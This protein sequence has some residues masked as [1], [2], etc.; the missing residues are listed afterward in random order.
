MMKYIFALLAIAATSQVFPKKNF[1]ESNVTL[2]ISRQ[3]S[4]M[5][6]SQG[7]ACSLTL[8]WLWARSSMRLCT[9][10]TATTVSVDMKADMYADDV[11]LCL[12]DA[13]FVDAFILDWLP[14]VLAEFVSGQ[15]DAVCQNLG[16]CSAVKE[17]SCADCSTTVHNLAKWLES[18]EQVVLQV[19]FLQE[20]GCAGEEQCSSDVEENYPDM[21]KHT[22]QN[23]IVAVA[24]DTLC[25][26]FCAEPT[27]TAAPETTM[28]GET[29]TMG[30]E[31][32]TMGEE[33]TTMG[34]ET[35]TMVAEE[36]TTA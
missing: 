29:T 14:A 18:E 36:T 21:I 22:S 27:T 7:W 1:I 25:S 3:L 26:T 13:C 30:A 20:G 9:I 16:I 34:E 32:T 17:V 28:G 33:S 4:V 5:S 10:T 8:S 2:C 31:T 35:T 12:G 15:A 23:F 24:T 19:A 6:V 11:T